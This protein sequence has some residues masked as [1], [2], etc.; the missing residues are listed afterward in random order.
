MEN[1]VLTILADNKL[2]FD[3]VKKTI[4]AEFDLDKLN[5]SDTN[6]YLGQVVRA[7]LA[8]IRKVEEAFRKIEQYKTLLKAEEKKNPAR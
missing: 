2:L 1:S 3:E 4:L 8:G 6:E 5:T 7:R